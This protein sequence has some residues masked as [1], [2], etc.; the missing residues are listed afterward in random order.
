MPISHRN[1]GVPTATAEAPVER[2][3]GKNSGTSL[4]RVIEEKSPGMTIAFFG[5]A[6][7]VLMY[8]ARPNEWIMKRVGFAQFAA[9]IALAGFVGELVLNGKGLK[10]I[11]R[12]MIFLVLLFLHLSL[13]VPFAIWTGGAYQ[14]VF[15]EFSKIVLIALCAST[16]V[17]TL[18]RLRTVLFIQVFTVSVMVLLSL[19][20]FGR[21]MVDNAGQVRRTGIVSGVFQN[22]NDFAVSIS[23]V[24]PI[25]LWFFLRS[26]NVVVKLFWLVT[27]MCMILAVF[28]TLSRSG[29]LALTFATAITVWQIGIRQKRYGFMAMVL[30]GTLGIIAASPGQFMSR[31]ESI[32]DIN[33]DKTGSAWGRR[34]LME[35]SFATANANPLLGIGPGNFPIVSGSWHGAHSTFGQLASEAGYPAMLLFIMMLWRAARNMR[36]VR[37]RFTR[38]SD[39][40][41]LAGAMQ[42]ALGGYLVG[43]LFGDTAYH[44]FPYLLIAYASAIQAITSDVPEIDAKEAPANAPAFNKRTRFRTA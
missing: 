42:A 37:A 15:E 38:D 12:D 41:V 13:A 25:A 18:K 11:P 9:I 24:F 32:I 29:F 8:C 1:G 17:N 43:A 22:P 33:K 28:Q 36:K 44:F 40:G 10:Q 4:R 26:R 16:A 30:L 34:A 35:R 14:T 20:G 27:S 31:M 39:T 7:F 2:V 21:V 23:I 19:A 6:M 5:L 3:E